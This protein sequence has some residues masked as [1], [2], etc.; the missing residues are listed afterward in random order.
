MAISSR[1]DSIKSNDNTF[2][3]DTTISTRSSELNISFNIAFLNGMKLN[4]D[5]PQG[6]TVS[7][8]ANAATAN[9]LTGRLPTPVSVKF[10]EGEADSKFSVVLNII[11]CT[12]D[13][14]LPMKLSVVFNVH[15]SKEAPTVVT[16]EKELI[17]Q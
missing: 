17:V 13:T 1:R 12:I 5:A 3:F 2:I 6:W 8:P 16:E 15:R 9:A 7:L 10:P 11:A 14:C 4:M